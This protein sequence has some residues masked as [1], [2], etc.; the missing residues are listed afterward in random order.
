MGNYR[1]EVVV[2][3]HTSS[4]SQMSCMEYRAAVSV[5]RQFSHCFS[6]GAVAASR[7]SPDT[8]CQSS[9][10]LSQ[11]HTNCPD[12]HISC[13]LPCY[14]SNNNSPLPCPLG[15]ITQGI[16]NS[17]SITCSTTAL[18]QRTRIWP[19]IFPNTGE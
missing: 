10:A 7:I 16:V 15:E 1:P 17:S 3:E 9:L 8:L 13:F 5:S 12:G 19:F 2:A 11:S 14:Q 6:P 18:H 4:G